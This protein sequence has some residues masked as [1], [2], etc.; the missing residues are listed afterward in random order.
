MVAP[1]TR[2]D[3]WGQQD[4]FS[5][6]LCKARI[7]GQFPSLF[8]DLTMPCTRFYPS[9]CSHLLTQWFP[10]VGFQPLAGLE[11]TWCVCIHRIWHSAWHCDIGIHSVPKH[12]VSFVSKEGRELPQDKYHG[13]T[14]MGEGKGPQKQFNNP[15]A[16]TRVCVC[17]YVRVR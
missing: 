13:A 2:L 12:E 5:D 9:T 1:P 10:P 17:V 7:Y 6:A 8:W 11:C 15:G 16:H 14:D 3:L 4:I